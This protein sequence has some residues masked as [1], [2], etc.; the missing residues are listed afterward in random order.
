ML[1]KILVGIAAVIAILVVVIAT[2][3]ADFHLERST[4]VATG[5]ETPFAQ[6]NDF[7]AWANWSP[8]DKLD[9][10]MTRTY[11]GP[12]SGVGSTYAWSGNDKAGEGKMTIEQS[13]P[14]RK[15]AIK[16]E[17]TKPFT[18]TN[19]AT[20]DFVPTGPGTTKVTWSMDGKNGF[21]GKAASLFMDMDKLVG[22]DFE[23]G[24]ASLKAVS[25]GGAG[26][27]RPAADAANGAK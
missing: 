23:R 11:A 24:L 16:L 25:E 19:V 5:P 12:S 20:F 18:A 22:G 1:V 17:F 7:H 8:Y 4:V 21:M 27:S 3:P 15:I 6:V 13:D 26:S 9:P 14:A 2:R 10:T